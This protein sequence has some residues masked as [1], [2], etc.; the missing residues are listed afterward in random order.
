MDTASGRYRSS[1]LQMILHEERRINCLCLRPPTSRSLR[2]SGHTSG[3]AVL[4]SIQALHNKDFWTSNFDG[5]RNVCAGD[6]LQ[7]SLLLLCIEC[8]HQVRHSLLGA[9]I[10]VTLW[11]GG[12]TIVAWVTYVDAEPLGLSGR[13]INGLI[14]RNGLGNKSIAVVESFTNSN[15]GPSSQ[16]RS[17]VYRP[18]RGGRGIAPA[19]TSTC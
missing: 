15:V 9:Y 8:F 12:T 5:C 16:D 11:R 18:P 17:W 1:S 14:S 2:H 13:L 10:K 19:T 4:E 6:N 3:T 7:P